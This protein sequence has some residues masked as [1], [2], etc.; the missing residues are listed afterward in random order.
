MSVPNTAGRLMSGPRFKTV[1]LPD[2]YDKTAL[3]DLNR[4]LGAILVEYFIIYNI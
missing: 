4:T 1:W 2:D 3:E